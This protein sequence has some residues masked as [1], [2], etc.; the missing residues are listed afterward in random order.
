MVWIHGG[1]FVFGS[2]R[3]AVVRRHAVRAA[4]R[5]RRRHDQL[6]PRPV[7]L[8]AP[9][10]PRSAPSSRLRQRRHP[11]P[12][13]RARVGA[14]Q[15]RRVRRRSRRTSRS[16]A[17]RPAAARS[18]RCSA[19]PAA[20]GLFQQGDRRRAARRRGGRHASA[21]PGSRRR[22]I[23]QARRRAPATSTRCAR[24]R[25]SNSSKPRPN[26]GTASPSSGGAAV[27]A[28]GRRH[29]APAA[30]ARR[31]RRR[32]RRGRAPAR[33]HEPAR[34]DAVQ[35]AG[36]AV[37]RHRRSTASRRC[38]SLGTAASRPRSSPTTRARRPDASAYGAVDGCRHRRRV[39]HAR[40]S[41]WPRRS[42]ATAPPW[43]YLFTWET[44]VF[45]GLL[46]SHA[47]ARDPVRVRQSRPRCGAV[48]RRRARASAASPTRCTARGSRS[49]AP[50]TR[51]IPGS[52]LAGVR[53]RPAGH[54]ALRRDTGGP[55]RPDERGPRGLGRVPPLGLE[56]VPGLLAHE[57]AHP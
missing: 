32:Q 35:H 18:A 43:M 3:H 57:A 29:R 20:R 39:P 12:G 11:R 1:A 49:P 21:R 41:G 7:R 42:A 22:S 55:R 56:Q 10:R 47:R 54:D 40:R 37:G 16:S 45:G 2:G 46:R 14:R 44:P 48:H 6:P 28:G 23:E 17:S 51:A 38:S 53:R 4:R 52:R 27:P 15:H 34:D 25:W 24:S 9:R 26:L 50:A 13:R 31:D 8:P 19:L 5:R 33:R 30:A 36:P